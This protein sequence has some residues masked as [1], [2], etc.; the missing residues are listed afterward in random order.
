MFGIVRGLGNLTMRV[1]ADFKSFCTRYI[2][3]RSSK[4]GFGFSRDL[5]VP[6]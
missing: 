5:Q 6:G 4:T 3:Y 2:E 1:F